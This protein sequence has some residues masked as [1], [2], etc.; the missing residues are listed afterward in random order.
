MKTLAA[1]TLA[2]CAPLAL[3]QDLPV[4]KMFKGMQG[5]QKGRWK[6]ELL[7]ASGRAAG[8]N[9][10][11]ITLCTDKLMDGMQRREKASAEAGCTHRLLKDTDDEA[12]VDSECKER[13][14][15]VTMKRESD[16]SMLMTVDATGPRGPE[17]LKIR[18]THRGPCRE[19]GAP[20]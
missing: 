14:S 20:N 6:M 5:D 12:V 13:K 17:S 4:P 16:K 3:A 15:T 7:E 18:Y 11:S 19:A 1:A 10:M 8:R 9:G 2:L